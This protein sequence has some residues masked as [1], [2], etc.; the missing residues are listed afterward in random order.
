MPFALMAGKDRINDTI[1][2]DFLKEKEEEAAL[3]LLLLDFADENLGKSR[4]LSF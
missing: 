4:L 2:Q 3:V 1:S